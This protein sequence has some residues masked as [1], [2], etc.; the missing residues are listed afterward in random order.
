MDR[1]ERILVLGDA[2]RRPW[3]SL[4]WCLDTGLKQVAIVDNKGVI[5]FTPEQ[6]PPEKTAGKR[7]RSR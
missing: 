6:E 5:I 1:K 3:R 4:N 7:K 2:Q